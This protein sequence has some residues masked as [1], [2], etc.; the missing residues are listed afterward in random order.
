[1]LWRIKSKF[2]LPLPLIPLALPTVGVVDIPATDAVLLAVTTWAVELPELLG[3]LTRLSALARVP[4]PEPDP[5]EDE[6]E[7]ALLCAE[8]LADADEVSELDELLERDCPESLPPPPPPP[9]RIPPP[10]PP[11]TR[12]TPPWAIP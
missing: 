7:L 2:W 4:P 6:A 3:V 1:M 5:D 10:P 8:L 12:T 11:P 9:P